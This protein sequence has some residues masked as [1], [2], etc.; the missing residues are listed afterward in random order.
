MEP[1][2]PADIIANAARAVE[3][4]KS[5]DKV[6]E[7]LKQDSKQEITE[8]GAR[9]RGVFGCNR[10]SRMTD[11]IVGEVCRRALIEALLMERM[12]NTENWSHLVEFPEAPVLPSLS[13]EKGGA[14]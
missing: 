6:I 9:I 11:V 4:V 2:V 14:A 3:A 7:W 12:V 13:F 5:I 1:R 10:L 8:A